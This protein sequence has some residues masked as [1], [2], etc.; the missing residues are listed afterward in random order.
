[1]DQNQNLKRKSQ[2][3]WSAYI[4]LSPWSTKRR[5]TLIAHCN[6]LKSA[7]RLPGPPRTK[8]KRLSAI[9]RSVSSMKDLVISRKPSSIWTCSRAF[10]MRFRIA[11]NYWRLT[12][13]W[14][15]LILKMEIFML[16]RNTSRR[17][18]ESRKIN[19]VSIKPKL[20][21]TWS[22]VFWITNKVL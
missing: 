18:R 11:K 7:S 13:N 17:W 2:R 22:L 4:K 10:A 21:L 12:N 6:T 20:M 5:M 1:M 15:R 16:P 19:V 9:R 3:T 14:E 8:N